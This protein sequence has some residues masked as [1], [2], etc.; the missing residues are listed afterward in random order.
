MSEANDGPKLYLRRTYDNP[1]AAFTVG[2]LYEL[3][4]DNRGCRIVRDDDKA[5]IDYYP[6]RW[7]EVWIL[8]DGTELEALE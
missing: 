6:D 4:T 8:P 2:K 3:T 5:D 7:Q 1:A